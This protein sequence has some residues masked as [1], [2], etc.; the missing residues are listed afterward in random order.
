M[1]PPLSSNELVLAINSTGLHILSAQ[2]DRLLLYFGF[3]QLVNVN[4]NMYYIFLIKIHKFRTK[5]SGA[6]SL[7]LRTLSAGGCV[8]EWTFQAPNA[9]DICT[10]LEQFIGGLQKRSKYLIVVSEQKEGNFL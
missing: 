4:V 10:L 9:I 8:E 3:C 5:R 7:H 6:D 2:D 1:G